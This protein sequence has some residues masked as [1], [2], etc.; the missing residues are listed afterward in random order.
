MSRLMIVGASFLQL[1]AIKRAKELGHYVGVADYDPSAV[2]IPFA[3]EYYNASTINQDAIVKAAKEFKADGIMTLATDMPMRSVAAVAEA[4]NLPGISME[5][6]IKATDKGEMI[7]AFKSFGVESPWYFIAK[8]RLEFENLRGKLSYPCILKPTD[9][10]GS[11]G[12]MLVNNKEDLDEAYEFS[13]SNGRSGTVI[14]EEYMIGREVSVEI[15]V[16]HGEVHILAVTDKL[17][18]G[19][20]HFVELGHN[21]PSVLPNDSV[22]LIKDLAIRAVK[23]IGL[24]D[25]PAHVEIMLTDDGP[26]MVELGA[27]MGGDCIT[28]HLVPYSTGID[29][30]KATIDIALGIAPDIKPR[31]QKGSAIRFLTPDIGTVVSV[32]GIDEARSVSGIKDIS[33]SVNIGDE[34]KEIESSLNRSGYVIAQSEDALSAIRDCEKAK[35]SIKI[36]TNNV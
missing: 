4:M 8:D 20:P 27:R 15:I 33:V 14:V 28:T 13:R 23:S 18:T 34:V 11:R 25:G 29:M 19:A 22:K 10:A 21:Q 9:N 35:Q 6:A 36:L 7:K 17:T 12:V 16:Y 3:D 24:T 32:K 31:F 30:I 5:T 2:G 1:P 26:K